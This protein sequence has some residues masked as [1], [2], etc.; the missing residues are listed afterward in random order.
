MVTQRLQGGDRGDRDRCRFL[1]RH[2]G[3]LPDEARLARDRVLGPGAEPGAEHLVAG[4]ELLHVCA[5]GLDLSREVGPH[6]RLLGPTQAVRQPGE[7]RPV[8]AVPLGRVDGRRMHA[9]EYLVRLE[10]GLSTSRSS[11][12]SGGLY[13]SETIAFIAVLSS[14]AYSVS[15]VDVR[16]KSVKHMAEPTRT[17]LSRERVLRTGVALADRG[18]IEA[19]SMRKLAQELGV[20]AMSLY[21]HVTNK[22]D[23]L[24]GIVE[25]SRRDRPRS[26]RGRLEGRHAAQGD[27][28]ARGALG[29]LLGR[30]PVDVEPVVRRRADALRRVGPAGASGEAAS[31]PI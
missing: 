18:G 13:R 3:R 14:L 26:R 20:E 23:L 11:S 31:R 27:L 22:D 29:A 2:V 30:Q 12:A 25:L 21:N 9:D 10:R 15:R 6:G 16:R 1:P 7:E 8:H 5:D 4:L 17:P 19:L 24:D 28:G